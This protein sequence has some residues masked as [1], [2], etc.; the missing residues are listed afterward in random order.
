MLN[1]TIEPRDLTQLTRLEVNAQTMSREKFDRLTANI[2]ADGCLTSV[3]LIWQCPEE[4]YPEFGELILSGNHRADAAVAA[5][6]TESEC[7]VITG[8]LEKAQ[9]I[10]MQ[11]SHNAIVGE[12]DLATL[13]SLYNDIDDLD[14]RHYA[15]LDDRELGLLNDVQLDSLAEAQLDYHTIQVAFLP[16]EHQQA[17]DAFDKLSTSADE[18]WLAGFGQYEPTLSALESVAGSH[19][20]GNIATQLGVVLEIFER[21]LDELRDGFMDAAGAPY[22]AKHDVPWEAVIGTRR[23]A[24][25][26]AATIAQAIRHATA[27]EQDSEVTPEAPWRLLSRLCADYLRNQGVR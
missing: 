12:P 4:G 7:M 14:W 20:I 18:T 17:R 23:G 10:A 11:I 27:D 26:E 13:A 2:A 15:G 21:H 24:A 5:G 25:A 6:V 8:P 19:K 16:H 1:R 9:R 3:P 22:S